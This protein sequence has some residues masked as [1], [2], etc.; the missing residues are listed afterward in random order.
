MNRDSIPSGGRLRQSAAFFLQLFILNP[1]HHDK[2]NNDRG[3]PTGDFPELSGGN[4]PDDGS[5][6][7]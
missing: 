4:C 7:P 2:H 1:I 3:Q 6:N 5:G